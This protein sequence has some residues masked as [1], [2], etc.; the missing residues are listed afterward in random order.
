MLSIAIEIGAVALVA[1][2]FFYRRV[3]FLIGV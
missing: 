1:A 3:A 2:L